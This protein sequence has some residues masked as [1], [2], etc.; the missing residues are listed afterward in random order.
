[1]DRTGF[2]GGSDMSLILNGDWLYLWEVKTGREKSD[3][4]SDVFPVQLGIATEEWHIDQ[5]GKELDTLIVPAHRQVMYRVA[6]PEYGAIPLKGT[7]DA[8]IMS[9]KQELWGIEVKHTNER[10]TM[11]S[12]LE[13]YMPQ[14]QFYMYVSGV[15]KM[16]LS[17]I[18]GNRDRQMCS[19][20]PDSEFQ[21]TM[22]SA[23]EEFWGYVTSDQRPDSGM[24]P[25]PTSLDNVAINDMVA[26]CASNDNQF[27]DSAMTYLETKDAHKAHET[28]KKQLK[29]MI[30]HN[31]RELYN[32][33][34]AL[35]RA[36]NGSI[37]FV[38][39][40]D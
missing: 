29:G 8:T 38:S 1:M 12:Q 27:G 33:V 24:Q 22:L 2:L 37:R 14:L 17:C 18:F 23:A 26:R 3:D 35:R 25:I 40:E 10:A 15:K 39:M 32:D 11:A 7:L 20:N 31:E 16:W 19:V 6:P 36:A 5:V 13:R 30:A 9:P 34:L 21:H 4:L 28:C